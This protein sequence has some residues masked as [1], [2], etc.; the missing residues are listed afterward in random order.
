MTNENTH[1]EVAV[2]LPVFSTY[3]YAVPEPLQQIITPGKRVLVPFG[4]RKVTGYALGPADA[5]GIQNIK[6]IIE[7]LDEL[8]LFP[9]SMIPL[10]KWISDYYIHP[11]GEVIKEALPGGININE[12]VT[13]HITESGAHIIADQ[14]APALEN[15]ILCL[16]KNNSCRLNDIPKKLKR[17]VPCHLIHK[18]EK[19]GLVTRQ[20]EIKKA[21]TCQ[22]KQRF[23]ALA[24]TKTP[25][26]KL[27]APKR[28]ILELAEKYGEI[29]VSDLKKSVPTASSHVRDLAQKGC[30][31]VFDKPVYRDPFGESVPSDTPPK[32]SLEQQYVV[33][34][35]LKAM[36]NG[37]A[38]FLLAGVTGSGKT[39]VYM[40]VTAEAIKKNLSVLVLVPEIAL[41]SEIERRFRAR[42]G[43]CVA[44]LHS[45]LSAGERYDQ[46]VRIINT[47]C[48][49]VI[50]AR[51][52]IFAPLTNIGVIIVDEEH[53]TS[54]KQ[55]SR[56]RYNARD[57][58]II[59]ARQEDSIALLGSA[60]PSIQS[61]YNVTTGKF[62]E[63]NLKK[64]IFSRS[65]PDIRV[66]DLRRHKDFRG[67]RRFITTDLQKAIKETLDREE[68]VLLFLNRRGFASF[69]V[70]AGCGEALKCKNCDITLTLHQAANA[71][72]CHLCGYSIPANASCNLCGSAGI[73]RLGMGTE[74]IETTIKGLFPE[75]RVARMDR[76][77]I[78]RK[79]SLIKLLKGLRNH[80]IDI[81]IG[82]QMVAKGHDFPGITLVGIICA[83]LS[84]SFPDFRAGELTFQI[85]AQVSGRAGRGTRPGRVILQ[86]YNPD[87][88]SIKAATE[89]NFMKFYNQE[90]AFRKAFNYP[91]FSRMIQ[92]KISG[93]N[94]E[95]VR[96]RATAIGEQCAMLKKRNQPFNQWIDILG[97]IEAPLARVA[98]RYRWQII[99][100]SQST[101][102]LHQFVRELLFKNGQQFSHNQVRV[103]IDV[104]PFFMM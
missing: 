89:Q 69:P 76:D 55:E 12:C 101:D 33:S 15:D 91:P 85:L 67:T 26:V 47:Q 23:I 39:E 3:T 45:G 25:I 66:V 84:L 40:H 56:F 18:M 61:I 99:I 92:L 103:A 59:R 11:L 9:E 104:D 80:D 44:V 82:T 53:D 38:T 8:P 54:Y 6:Q 79:G 32:L 5:S 41:I 83:D 90:I 4:N 20:R 52:A 7:I 73:K 36:G 19:N 93:P 96:Q 30:I 97:P 43:E 75:A 57:M 94:R 29:S 102:L 35:V 16:I 81:L 78:T 28:K 77:T 13:L 46:W 17:E 95:K 1:I 58:A 22:K 72:K 70:C 51:S 37:F 27:S 49:I 10:F 50:G 42:F 100:K 48:P 31:S 74:K 2:T 34:K 71:Y 62:N 88:F 21:V 86:T 65:L 98:R 24:Q 68:Q 14:C 87:H 60:T 63:L 64:R